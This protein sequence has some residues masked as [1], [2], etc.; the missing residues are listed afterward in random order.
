MKLTALVVGL[1]VATIGTN[2]QEFSPGWIPDQQ[3][4][5]TAAPPVESAGLLN[6]VLTSGPVSSL[7]AKLGINITKTLEKPKYW[8]ERIP[9]ITDNNY[10]DVIVNEP[11]SDEEEQARTWVFIM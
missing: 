9:L 1:F 4:A 2:A 11:L 5:T 7:F 8:D 6:S 10:Q 3:A